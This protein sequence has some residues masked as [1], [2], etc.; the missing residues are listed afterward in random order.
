MCNYNK[1]VEI[2]VLHLHKLQAS[3]NIFIIDG[4]A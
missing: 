2:E 3:S 4:I 1:M